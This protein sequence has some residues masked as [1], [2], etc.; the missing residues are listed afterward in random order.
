[1]TLEKRLDNLERSNRNLRAVVMCLIAAITLFTVAARP[2]PKVLEAE[3]IVLRDPNGKERGQLFATEKAWGLVLYT[4]NGQ[5]ALDL[6]AS[7]TVNGLMI[8]DQNGYGRQIFTS[9]TNQTTWGIFH[10]GSKPAQIEITD[11]QAGAEIVVRDRSDVQRIELGVTDKGPG[12]A[13]SDTN[14][15]MRTVLAEGLIASFSKDGTINWSPE[16][17]RLSPEEKQK[18]KGL[19]PKM[20]TGKP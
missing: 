3:K 7:T 19:S 13:L 5:Q 17:E 15:T 9:D 2:S 14:G 8:S 16:W 10:P 20:P 4:E 18:V 11:K 6:V 1:M 12:L